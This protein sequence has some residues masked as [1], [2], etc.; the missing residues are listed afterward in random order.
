MRLI[1]LVRLAL[2]CPLL[3]V[4]SELI[5]IQEAKADDRIK[6]GVTF[7]MT[8]AISL[9]GEGFKNGVALAEAEINRKASSQGR[10]L[11]VVYADNQGDPKAAL[12]NAKRFID[13]ENVSGILGSFDFLTIPIVP[14]LEKKKTVMLSATIYRF[15]QEQIPKFTFTG[16]WN[17][18]TVGKRYGLVANRQGIN[19]VGLI[20]IEDSSYSLFRRGFDSTFEGK[21]AVEKTFP[22]GEK[23]LRSM[24]FQVK[25]KKPDGL[26]V[27]GYPEDT[28]NTLRTLTSLHMNDA[29]LLILEGTE[30][31]VA[32]ANHEILQ[33]TRA[34]TL[35]SGRLIGQKYRS[36]VDLYRSYFNR[37][38]RFEALI[39]YD[40]TIILHSAASSCPK[41]DAICIAQRVAQHFN[42]RHGRDYGV[43]LAQYDH[44]W[45]E[46]EQGLM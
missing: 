41:Q 39:S 11:E 5:L 20:A 3:V 8:G 33:S 6:I 42:E 25:Q 23:D 10:R 21:V 15:P 22:S 9:Y 29:P 35:A 43:D 36:F 18:E 12:L 1:N 30:D 45:R 4:N 19:E 38:P 44:G 13:V 26:V 37:E 31:D 14:I 24:L 16:F 17:P 2:F 34:I 32:R 27:W 7:P 28:A 40:F 46:I